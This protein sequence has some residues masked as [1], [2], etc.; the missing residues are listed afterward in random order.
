M[1]LQRRKTRSKS[2][3]DGSIV[4]ICTIIGAIIDEIWAFK[5]QDFFM[6]HPVISIIIFWAILMVI[7]LIGLKLFGDKDD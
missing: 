1:C 6:N 3:S 7:N 4:I 2:S 5:W